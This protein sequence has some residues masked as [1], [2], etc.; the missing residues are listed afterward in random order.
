MPEGMPARQMTFWWWLE[1]HGLTRRQVEEDMDLNDLEWM[2][3]IDAA[4]T[5]AIEIKQKQAAR[6]ARHQQRRGF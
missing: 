3:K 4:K 1:N 6:E 5:R 2:P